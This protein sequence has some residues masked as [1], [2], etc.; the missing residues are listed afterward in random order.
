MCCIQREQ[1]ARV[2]SKVPTDG[3]TSVPI[4]IESVFYS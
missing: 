3:S 1:T 4:D 2:R